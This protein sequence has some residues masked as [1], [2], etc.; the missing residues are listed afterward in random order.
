MAKNVYIIIPTYNEAGNIALLLEQ[1]HTISTSL[2]DYH[3]EIL[4][5][6]DSSPDGTAEIV[7]SSAQQ[8]SNIHLLSGPKEGMGAA[9]TR[10]ISAVINS[11]DIIITMDADFSHP[12]SMIPQF[13]DKIE[14]GYDVVIGSRYIEGG[15][16]PDWSFTRQLISSSANVMARIIAG[17]YPVH[18]CTSSYRAIRASFLRKISPESLFTKGYAFTTTSL[19]EYIQKN[20]RICEIPLV[21]HNRTRGTT[22]LQSSDIIEYFFNCFRLRLK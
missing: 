15:G 1:I 16:T 13:L 14:E 10:A 12:P 17:L 20:A 2:Q 3:I 6:D 9:Y 21:F 19:W 18:D 22:K 7:R 5:A 4:V 8:L 11:C